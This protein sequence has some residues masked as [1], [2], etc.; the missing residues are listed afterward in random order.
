MNLFKKL[1][2]NASQKSLSIYSS[3]KSFYSDVSAASKQKLSKRQDQPFDNLCSSPNPRFLTPKPPSKPNHSKDQNPDKRLRLLIK[4]KINFS[5]NSRKLILKDRS[6]E[7]IG[8]T[9]NNSQQSLFK[10][11]SF[12]ELEKTEEI[13]HLKPT[14][15]SKF[16][17]RKPDRL[18]YKKLFI[19]NLK[20]VNASAALKKVKK[21]KLRPA[22]LESLQDVYTLSLSIS[23]SAWS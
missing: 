3:N 23:L 21:K 20:Q 12:K 14:D 6:F 19:S 5:R 22:K 2:N 11:A 9:V 4:E 13:L 16:N 15:S 18:N 7:L 17:F 10:Q 1:K 8:T